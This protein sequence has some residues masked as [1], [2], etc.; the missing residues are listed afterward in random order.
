MTDAL[1]HLTCSFATCISS[2]G[3]YLLESLVPTFLLAC[4]LIIVLWAFF[5]IPYANTLSNTYFANIFFQAMAH[6]F[7]S[8]TVSFKVQ[9]FFVMMKSILSFFSF[10]EKKKKLFVSSLSNLCMTSSHKHFLLFS[11]RSFSLYVL[12]YD[13]FWGN[14]LFVM[15]GLNQDLF[16]FSYRC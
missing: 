16:I 1:E 14:F 13:P 15:W 8:L 12:V 10:T 4:F 11:Y 7:I 6:L 9:K 3:K 2:L 5:Y